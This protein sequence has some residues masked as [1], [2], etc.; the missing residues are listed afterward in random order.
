MIPRAATETNSSQVRRTRGVA[1][2][3]HESNYWYEEMIE[4]V[5]DIKNPGTTLMALTN[6]ALHLLPTIMS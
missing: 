5:K 2:P 1:A 6:S 4:D 3:T